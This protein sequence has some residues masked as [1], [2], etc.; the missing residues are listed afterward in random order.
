[1]GGM[2]GVVKDKRCGLIYRNGSRSCSGVGTLP[3]MDGQGIEAK[4]VITIDFGHGVL[5][6]C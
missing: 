3:G 4:D 2:F 1:M 6:L 5:L